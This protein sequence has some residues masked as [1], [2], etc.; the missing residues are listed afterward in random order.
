MVIA[1]KILIRM[2]MNGA[3]ESTAP[4]RIRRRIRAPIIGITDVCIKGLPVH[5]E[6]CI[7][8]L[9]DVTRIRRIP[10][11]YFKVAR[12]RAQIR[13]P[14]RVAQP[15]VLVPVWNSK[16]SGA[17]SSRDVREGGIL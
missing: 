12:V 10:L 13:Q 3:I 2:E 6:I 11:T 5:L 15:C 7:S 1:R 14:W 9:H 8:A 16:K 17:P 4:N